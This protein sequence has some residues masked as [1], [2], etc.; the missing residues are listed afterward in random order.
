MASDSDGVLLLIEEGKRRYR[1]ES[2][3][4]GDLCPCLVLCAGRNIETH[5]RRL[6]VDGA[7]GGAAGH[8]RLTAG[9][10]RALEVPVPVSRGRHGP[11]GLPLAVFDEPYPGER[12]SPFVLDDLADDSGELVFVGDLDERL[13]TG[14]HHQQCPVR[15][16][17]VRGP[18]FHF[19]LQL[20][21]G[22]A[23]LLLDALAVGD[24]AVDLQDALAAVQAAAEELS[25]GDNDLPPVFRSMVDLAE[26]FP[27]VTKRSLQ[28]LPSLGVGGLRE[29][30]GGSC[31]APLP[32][33]SHRAPRRPGSSFRC[34]RRSAR[35]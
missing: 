6:H 29:A 30:P 35:R 16:L 7:T 20:V 25:R 9:P 26:P 24:V 18:H 32:R 28:L 19:L 13:V 17:E 12:V 15:P 2:A 3:G 34:R 10:P 8:G 27:A 23:Q 33:N 14:A 31:P 5:D 1:P 21:M 4:Q 22:A 11:D